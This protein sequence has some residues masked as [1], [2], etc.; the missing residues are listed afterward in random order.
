MKFDAGKDILPHEYKGITYNRESVKRLNII[1]GFFLAFCVIA[2]LRTLQFGFE[3][4]EYKKHTVTLSEIDARADIVDRNGVI[5]ATNTQ[6]GHIKLY[7]P[8]VKEENIDDVARIIHEISPDEFS[9][10]DALKYIRSGKEG[11][12]LKKNI[13]GEQ[14]KEQLN[15]INKVNRIYDCFDFELITKRYY[16]QRNVFSHVV[17]FAG[18]DRGLEGIERTYDKYLRE[19]K[20]PLKISIDSRIQNIFHEQLTIAMNKYHAKGAMG[21]LMNST[22]G[23]MLAM[24]QLPDFNPNEIKTGHDEKRKF[25]LLRVPYEMG[26][27][28]KIFNTAIAYENNLQDRWYE[29]DKPLMIYDKF[30]RP[31]MK[32]PIDDVSSFKRSVIKKRGIKKLQA[33][34]IM[35]YS[36]NVG[37]ARMALEFPPTAQQEF[38]QRLHFDG[39]LDLEFGKTETALTHKT[40]GK[41]ERATAAFGHGVNVTPMHLLLGVNAMTN[42]GFYIY[43]TLLKRG[44]GA[45]R[46]ERVL[47]S[48]ISAKLRQI[49]YRIAEETTGKLARVE[50][51][52]IGGKTGSAEKRASDGSVDKSRNMTVFTGVFPIS[53]PQYVILI[54]L[55]EAQAEQKGSGRTAAQNAVPTAG[56]ILNGIMPL[57]FE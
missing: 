44:V 15:F 35:L 41:V 29:I 11:I 30:N 5:L 38:F 22:T 2:I 50:G 24:V 32:K 53:V 25:K 14:L 16:P 55:D 9:I 6:I 17:G 13:I 8:K 46:G 47:D 56:A 36:C 7:P 40:W 19:N 28:F 4:S 27:V 10:E 23:E 48:E 20:D 51:M 26:S 39:P 1:K 52:E 34:D 18:K 21:M 12:Y 31:A 3:N 43:P 45:I 49:M 57:L 54:M 42:G 37:S 33:P